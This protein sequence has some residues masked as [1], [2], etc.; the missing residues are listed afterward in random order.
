MKQLMPI[1]IIILVGGLGFL[2]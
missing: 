2:V 1:G